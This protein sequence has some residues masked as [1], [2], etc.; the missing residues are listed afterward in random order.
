MDQPHLQL[1]FFLF[2]GLLT[3]NL[4]DH[5]EGF[6]SSF[7]AAL[8]LGLTLD[9]QFHVLTTVLEMEEETKT[10][11]STIISSLEEWLSVRFP[12]SSLHPYGSSVSGL[13][14]RNESDVDIFFQ[15]QSPKGKQF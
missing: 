9:E 7:Q 2:A 14:F 12:G 3:G 13:A 4:V 5:L 1:H 10:Q 8:S 11:R 15:S 6:K